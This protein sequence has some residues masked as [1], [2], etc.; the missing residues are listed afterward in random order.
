MKAHKL[1]IY[2]SPIG[3]IVYEHDDHHLYGLSIEEDFHE[4]G[5]TFENDHFIE[6]ELDGY[7]HG[8][9]KHFDLDVVFEKGTP[10]QKMVWDE[11]L[12]IPFG[13]TKSYQDIANAVGNPKAVRAVGQACKKNPVG[14]VVPCHRVIGKNNKLTGYSGK[15]YIHIKKKLLDMEKAFLN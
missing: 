11:L 13:Q 15:N 6:Q 2:H 1:G 7:F 8:D 9:I 10:F 3:H 4:E 12:H 5:L 14:I